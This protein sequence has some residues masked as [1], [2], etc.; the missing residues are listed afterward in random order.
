[1]ILKTFCTGAI[2]TVCL[3]NV[4]ENPILV[5][6]EHSFPKERKDS[7]CDTASAC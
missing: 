4:E 2:E 6:F 7:Y 3:M 5:A 1:M